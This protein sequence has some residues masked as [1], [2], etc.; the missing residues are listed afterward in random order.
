M[1]IQYSVQASVGHPESDEDEERMM[2]YVYGDTSTHE[3]DPDILSASESDCTNDSIV[4][5]ESSDQREEDK[6]EVD[7]I[8]KLFGSENL[9]LEV[10][11]CCT[12][13]CNKKISK[14]IAVRYRWVSL[15]SN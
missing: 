2:C 15:K 5:N 6:T 3:D 4:S 7:A 8:M 9:N 13:G 14:D 1:N 10:A 12:M 11:N